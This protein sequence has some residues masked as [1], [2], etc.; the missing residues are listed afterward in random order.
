MEEA[1]PDGNATVA[2]CRDVDECAAPGNGGCAH[3]CENAPGSRR[4][5]CRAGFAPDPGDPDG[6]A[7]VDFDECAED[8]NSCQQTCANSPGSYSCGCYDG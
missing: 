1:G 4:C 6:A 5:L 3:L 7:C 8:A 2:T